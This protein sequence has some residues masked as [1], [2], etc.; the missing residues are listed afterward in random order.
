MVFALGSIYTLSRSRTHEGNPF[1]TQT[2]PTA[3]VTAKVLIPFAVISI[4]LLMGS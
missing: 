4:V 1:V 2:F 3:V